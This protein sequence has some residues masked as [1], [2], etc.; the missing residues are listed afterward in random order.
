MN[1]IAAREAVASIRA[2]TAFAPET[3]VVLGSGLGALASRISVQC[4]IPY[5]Q[6][7]QFPVPRVDGHEGRL[8]MGTVGDTRVALLQGRVHLY[9]GHSA[10]DVARPVR[11]LI[12]L[13]AKTIIIT[14]AAGGINDLFQP[15]DFMVIRDHLNLQGTN[16]L[17]G[18]HDA[19][20]GPRFPDMTTVYD[21]D[22]RDQIAQCAREEGIA[23]H[24]GVY[25]GVLGPAYETPAEVRMLKT[26]GA[27][28]VG[29]STV[30]E[31]IAAHHMGARVGGISLI[32]N[33]AAGISAV[34]LT[35]E[36]VRATADAAGEKFAGLMLRLLGS[37][38]P[39]GHD[40]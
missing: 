37:L 27:D 38:R 6:I 13:G 22:M 24:T 31:A 39:A 19:T 8:V 15:G 33:K 20:L 3:C 9:E 16:P 7:A 40:G 30:A 2:K 4:A 34:S 36:G 21:K 11:T 12:M 26:L 5:D 25:A 17:V 18:V 14:N 10:D 32:T 1:A 28:A 35:H 23:I 29:M